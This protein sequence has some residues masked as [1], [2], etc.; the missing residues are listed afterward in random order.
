MNCTSLLDII[1]LCQEKS[2]CSYLF[3]MTTSMIWSLRN[4]IKV[5]EATVPVGRI[6]SMAVENLQ[7]FQQASSPPQRVSPTV[8]Q[9]KMVSSKNLVGLGAIVHNDKGLV[10]ADYSQSIP[11]PT[12]VEMMEVLAA[13]SAVSLAKELNF[14]QV[15]IEGDADVIIRAI[16]SGGFSSSSFGHII[17]DIKLLSSAFHKVSYSHTCRQGNRVAHRL[18]RMACNFSPFQV[19]MEDIPPNVASVYLSDLPE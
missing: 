16:N 11:L 6:S 1:Q 7:E 13:C 2:N 8:S 15:I 18:A 9:S 10:M 5:G 3:A 4:Q 17:R 19:W 14:D 12:S